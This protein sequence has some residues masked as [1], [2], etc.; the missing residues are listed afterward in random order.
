LQPALLNPRLERDMTQPENMSPAPANLRQTGKMFRRFGWFG[1]WAEG[2]LVA[3]AGG[4]FLFG[5]ARAQV[6]T[7]AG[8][9]SPGTGG[10][11]F[12]LALSLLIQLYVVF[13]CFQCVQIG[14][15]LAAE[16]PNFRPKKSDTIQFLWWSILIAGTGMLLAILAAQAISGTLLGRSAASIAAPLNPL[17]INQIIQP[18]YL[19]VVL[20]NTHII[21]AQ[22]IGLAISLWLLYRISR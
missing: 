16:N 10:G 4:L 15:R 12:L 21:T 2:I 13:R 6:P 17:L 11:L 20:A 19:F 14:R 7:P 9:T 18:L 22:F 1:V 8:G 3:V 5:S